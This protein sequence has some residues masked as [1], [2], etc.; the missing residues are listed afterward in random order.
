VK[1]GPL[2][3]PLRPEAAVWLFHRRRR[4]SGRDDW[5]TH[6]GLWGQFG[7]NETNRCL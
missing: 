7:A 1:S 4:G 6:E 2:D 5:R 3:H